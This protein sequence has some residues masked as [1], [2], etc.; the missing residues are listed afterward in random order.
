[1]GPTAG[2]LPKHGGSLYCRFLSYC[3]WLHTGNCDLSVTTPLQR[4]LPQNKGPP[5]GDI[6]LERREDRKE[7]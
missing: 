3:D 5:T 6:D 2:L 1:M 7:L 4:T